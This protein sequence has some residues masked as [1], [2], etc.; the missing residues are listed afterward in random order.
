MGQGPPSE[1]LPGGGEGDLL[2][3]VDGAFRHFFVFPS[4]PIILLNNS[5]Y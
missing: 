5:Y 2:D 3:V 1:H 4:L